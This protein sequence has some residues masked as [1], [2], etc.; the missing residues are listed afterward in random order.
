[1]N[2]NRQPTPKQIAL[3]TALK[4]TQANIDLMLKGKQAFNHIR[5]G[6]KKLMDLQDMAGQLQR[7]HFLTP[8]QMNY[9]EGIYESWMAGIGAIKNDPVLKGATTHHD[10]KKGLRYG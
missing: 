8:N 2:P 4:S 5:N 7:E 9:I 1:M 6:K 10:K 3:D